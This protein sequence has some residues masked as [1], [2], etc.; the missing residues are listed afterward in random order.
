MDASAKVSIEHTSGGSPDPSPRFN[1]LEYLC[2]LIGTCFNL[3]V[4]LSAAVFNFAPNLWPQAHLP[5][6]SMRLLVTGLVFAGSGSLFAITPLGKLS[7][8]HINPAVSLAFL[9]RGKMHLH[10]FIWYVISQFI[11]A[12]IGAFLLVWVWHG[13]AQAI[14]NGMTTVGPGHTIPF[15][16]LAETVMT[17]LLVFAIF[18]FLSVKRLTRWTPFMTWILVAILVWQGAAITGTSLNPARSF[19]PALVSW[20]FQNQWIYWL[21]PSLGALLA[22][23]TFRFADAERK[24]LTAKLFHAPEYSTIFKRVHLPS[25]R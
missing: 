5:S 6:Q 12:I 14:N 15:A 24:V 2:E 1:A 7:G 13:L 23:W 9:L 22:V 19:G 11:G 3:F 10:D 21:A 16:F 20:N 4:G 8:A 18:S 17:F 25:K